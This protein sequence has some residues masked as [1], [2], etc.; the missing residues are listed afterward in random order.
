MKQQANP[1]RRQPLNTRKR[2]VLIILICGVVILAILIAGLTIPE[3][4]YANDFASKKQAP[5]LQ[6]PFGTDVVGRDMLFRS[7]KGLSTSLKIGLF[8]S[9]V[10]AVAALFLGMA[11]AL[12]GKRV[13]GVI[14]WM[15]DLCM[16]LPHMVLLIMLCLLFGKGALGVTMSVAL[17]HWPNITRIIRAE[18]K[19]LTTRQ[20]V[21]S[22][23]KLGQSRWRIAIFHIVPHVF[24]QFIV[25]LVLLFPHAIMHEASV[26]FLGF[27]LSMDSPAIG[28]ILSESMKYLTVGMWWLALLPGLLLITIVLLFHVLGRNVEKLLNPATGQL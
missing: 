12:F 20:F 9:S 14:T 13:D 21:K 8:A 11:A 23:M 19:Q 15:V 28:V 26:T 6:H 24:P 22:S 5:S 17:T 4:A 27:G 2:L 16:S 3:S 25:G 1:E 18:V 10:S 7:L